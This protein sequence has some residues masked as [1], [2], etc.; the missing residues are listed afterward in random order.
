M[1]VV[2]SREPPLPADTEARVASFTELVAT[3]IANAETHSELIRLAEEQA[4]LRRLAT[5]V[6]RGVRPEK[7]FAAV[8]EM[9]GKLLGVQYAFMG[10]YEPDGAFAVVAGWGTA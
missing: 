2:S 4:A 6:A 3:A 8:T 1:V 7:V 5:L 10:R 9:I